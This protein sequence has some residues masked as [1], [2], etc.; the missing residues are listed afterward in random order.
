MNTDQHSSHIQNKIALG[1]NK[2]QVYDDT[3]T[4]NFASTRLNTTQNSNSKH[5]YIYFKLK[6]NK[7]PPTPPS[8]TGKKNQNNEKT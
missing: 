1:R 6:K 5:T 7:N 3:R 4:I 8:E 2:R